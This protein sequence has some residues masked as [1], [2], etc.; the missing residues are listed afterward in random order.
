MYINKIDETHKSFVL[1]FLLIGR[2]E[3]KILSRLLLCAECAAEFAG[4]CGK[5]GSSSSSSSSVVVE[6]RKCATQ[7]VEIKFRIKPKQSTNQKEV[8]KKELENFNKK[9]HNINKRKPQKLHK[10]SEK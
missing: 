1:L 5:C 10:K 7:I 6:R 4:V 2:T 3:Q 8:H 9:E